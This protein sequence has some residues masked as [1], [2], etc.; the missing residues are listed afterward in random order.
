[1]TENEFL[2]DTNI[3]LAIQETITYALRHKK[4][5]ESKPDFWETL[6]ETI[7]TFTSQS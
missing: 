3:A 6:S 2:L 7:K 1:M 5:R 4:C